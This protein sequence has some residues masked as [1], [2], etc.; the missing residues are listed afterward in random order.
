MKVNMTNFIA[1]LM[2][3]KLLDNNSFMALKIA[4]DGQANLKSLLTTDVNERIANVN[5]QYL[6]KNYK[7]N[8]K[9]DAIQAFRVVRKVKGNKMGKRKNQHLLKKAIKDLTTN[10]AIQPILSGP[11]FEPNMKEA[12]KECSK[13]YYGR[14]IIFSSGGRDR[15]AFRLNA[16][17]FLKKTAPYEGEYK[18]KRKHVA[19]IGIL[20]FN[21]Y[22]NS[23]KH[24]EMKKRK[25]Y[26]K[27][28]EQQC[29]KAVMAIASEAF[30][31]QGQAKLDQW[32]GQYAKLKKV[33]INHGITWSIKQ[34]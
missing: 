15:A 23:V 9:Q 6:T 17:M 7:K 27:H 30:A 19:E 21:S 4:A 11:P 12:L 14:S 32:Y 20:M 34:V 1:T 2:S 10:L 16:N 26:K 22:L 18:N 13:C 28:I 24:F 31:H 25:N 8:C 33:E 29:H 3:G 5:R